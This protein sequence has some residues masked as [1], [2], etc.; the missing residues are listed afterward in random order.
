MRKAMTRVPIRLAV[1]VAVLVA[2]SFAWAVWYAAQ[3]QVP[4]WMPLGLASAALAIA[5]V[6]AFRGKLLE[7]APQVL[8]GDVILPRSSRLGGDVTFLLPLQFSNGGFM[9]GIVEWVALRLTVDGEA[10]R[11]LLL[12]PIAEVDMQ[13]FIQARRRL[14]AE[15]VIEPFTSFSL[16]AKRAISKFVLFS[17]SDR[18]QAGPL[19]LKPGRYLFELFMKTPDMRR[20]RLERCFEHVLDQKNVDEYRKDTTVYLIN[21]E[22]SLPGVRREVAGAEWLPRARA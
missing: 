7:F 11:S 3:F 20:P 9:D 16:E 17:L 13:R 10:D 12:T 22:I 1:T 2:L 8:A 18:Q 5:L 21:Y 14:D 6:A 4:P 19:E 15:N